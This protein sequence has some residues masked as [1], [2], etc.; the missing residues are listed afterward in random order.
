MRRGSLPDEFVPTQPDM[1]PARRLPCVTEITL[2]VAAMIWAR[3]SEPGASSAR[4][5]AFPHVGAVSRQL[6]D[7]DLERAQ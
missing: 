5:Y 1:D 2:R 3:P 7:N 6:G 4:Q